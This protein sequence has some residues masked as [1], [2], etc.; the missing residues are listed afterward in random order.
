MGLLE[1]GAGGNP[2]PSWGG[3]SVPGIGMTKIRG[4]GPQIDGPGFLPSGDD[5][6]GKYDY[7]KSPGI[8]FRTEIAWRIW[9][10]AL[11][12]IDRDKTATRVQI[13]MQAIQKAGVHR[14][15][16]D[17]AELRLLEMGIEWYL[18]SPGAIRGAGTS[19]S[20]GGSLAGA[21]AP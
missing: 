1:F 3:F 9:N 16:I 7:R 18:T 21:G 17:P 20:S 19:I 6:G 8:G 14:G 13:L 2:N 10:A 11:S 12:I 5:D 4:G 15:Q